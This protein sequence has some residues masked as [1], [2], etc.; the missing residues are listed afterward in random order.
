[1]L[2]YTVASPLR[3]H[4]D[5]SEDGSEISLNSPETQCSIGFQPVFFR[6]IK[7]RFPSFHHYSEPQATV[8]F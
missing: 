8:K 2:H 6:T 5:S 7:R 3:V 1:M 4:G